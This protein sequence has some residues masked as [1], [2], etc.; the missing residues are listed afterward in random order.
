MRTDTRFGSNTPPSSCRINAGFPGGPGIPGSPLT[1]MPTGPRNPRRPRGPGRPWITWIHTFIFIYSYIR[2]K[3]R[4]LKA[5]WEYNEYSNNSLITV[6]IHWDSR[7][8]VTFTEFRSIFDQTIV[9]PLEGNGKPPRLFSLDMI[10]IDGCFEDVLQLWPL[11]F[12]VN[13]RL[14]SD[15]SHWPAVGTAEYQKKRRIV[16]PPNTQIVWLLWL[17]RQHR[18]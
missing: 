13:C 7:Y 6:L 18:V 11:F 4:W 3:S 14:P 10:P 17:L 8:V 1:P 16:V 2:V 15:G 9:V 12:D 5:T